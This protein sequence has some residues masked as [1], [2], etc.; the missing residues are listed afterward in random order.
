[1][2][3][4]TILQAYTYGQALTALLQ[5]QSLELRCMFTSQERQ[6][7]NICLLFIWIKSLL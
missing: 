3:G 7:Q 1:M 5:V 2:Q 6:L 4:V